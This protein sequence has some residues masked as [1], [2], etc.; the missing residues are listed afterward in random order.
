VLFDRR[1][2]CELCPPEAGIRGF[3]G[4]CNH[5]QKKICPHCW[6]EHERLHRQPVRD[7]AGKALY[8]DRPKLKTK[9]PPVGQLGLFDE[10]VEAKK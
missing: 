9:K 7:Y 1:S 5:C 10:P 2:A 6:P 4:I 3:C 8:K